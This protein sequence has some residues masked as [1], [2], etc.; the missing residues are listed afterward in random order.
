MGLQRT[1][2]TQSVLFVSLAMLAVTGCYKKEEVADDA[3]D[4]TIGSATDMDGSGGTDGADGSGD[5][6]NPTQTGSAEG[7]SNPTG[8]TDT[9]TGGGGDGSDVEPLIGALCDWEFKCC[10]DGERTYRLGPFTTDA[11]DCTERFTQQLY[12][13]DDKPELQRG[14]LLYTLGFGV[15][16]DRSTPNAQA[17]AD[18]KDLIEQQQCWE[19]AG[20]DAVCTPGGDPSQN[21]CDLRNLFTG[22]QK[23]GE[24][25]SE[26]LAGLGYDI[27]C[28]EGSSCEEK[29]GIFVC[30]DKGLVDEFCEADDKCDQ[31]L[32]CD[33]ASG[34]CA[35]RADEGEHCEF[36]DAQ[37][38]DVG[39]ETLPCLEHLTCDPQSETCIAYCNTYYDCAVDASCPEGES[40]IPVDYDDHTYTY[41]LERQNTNG[42]RCDT[43]HDCVDN[44]HCAG[45][46]CRTDAGLHDDCTAINE[47]EA[48][49]YCDIG[50]SGQCEIVVNANQPCS[51]DREC[52]PSTTIGC[53][54]SDDGQL[55]RTSQLGNGDVCVP[56]EHAANPT[57]NWCSTGVCE[58]A[59]DDGEANPECRIGASEGQ[60]CD[61]DYATDD[62][63]RCAQGLYCLEGVCKV[64]SEA[65]GGCHD[66]QGLQCLNASCDQIWE[67][68][69]CTDGVPVGRT[70]IVTCD[71][72]D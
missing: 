50:G 39:T 19:P 65:G 21:P 67:G 72:E 46:S 34:R 68:D 47:C 27:E 42:D 44:M 23:E 29:D 64:K 43:D 48:G 51:S 12:S 63:P 59:T 6:A 5:T 45:D 55:C 33:I 56:G 7:G 15:R 8:G 52:N 66:D 4:G 10:D 30:V 25:C 14:D 35:I 69:Y 49:L 26:A 24:P 31:G 54:T 18:C 40:C 71:G 16:L 58:D 3:A 20:E 9:D 22:T 32:Y 17:A 28:E 60:E 2:K 62:T 11:A 1:T 36:E 37:Q 41:C 57:G 38:P 53:I 13:N 70:D 61:E